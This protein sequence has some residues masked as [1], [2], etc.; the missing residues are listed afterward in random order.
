MNMPARHSIIS[1]SQVE[2]EENEFSD[3]DSDPYFYGIVSKKNSQ[4]FSQIFDAK[5]QSKKKNSKFTKQEI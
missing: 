1:L 2:K 4:E 5:N 3:M